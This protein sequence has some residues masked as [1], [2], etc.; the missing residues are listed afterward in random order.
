MNRTHT[1]NYLQNKNLSTYKILD[2]L[3]VRVEETDN[4]YGLPL[5]V[6]FG[7]AARKN[8]KRGF[9]FVSKILGKH[10]PVQPAVSLLGGALLGARIIEDV[11]GGTVTGREEAVTALMERKDGEEELEGLLAS[12]F[13]LPE[14]TL[15]IGFAETAT[16]LGQAVFDMFRN[17]SYIHTTR[18]NIPELA[19]AILFEEEHSHAV[20]QACYGDPE[21]F[22]QEGPIV[23]VDDEITTGKT[24]INIIEAIHSQY[25][26]REYIVASLLDWRSEEDKNRYSELEA[27]LGIKVSTVTLLGGAIEVSGCPVEQEGEY[28]YPHPSHLAEPKISWMGQEHFQ[29]Y[30]RM[31]DLPYL[32]ADSSGN[33][34]RIPYSAMTGRFRGIKDSDRPDIDYFAGRTGQLLKG[35][36]SGGRALCLGTGEFMYLPM[37]IAANM[38]DDVYF[39]STTRSPIHRVDREDYAV[40]S[41]FAF[42]CPDDPQVINHFYNIEYGQYRDI[43]L[44]ME[45][46]ASEERMEPLLQALKQTGTEHII[47]V[48]LNEE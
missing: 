14:H 32:S 15:F 28:L 6:L 41:G 16:S 7:M 9:L 5:D 26:H 21:L 2:A 20:S 39:Q 31:S 43:Y 10:I 23:L 29:A 47:V 33:V 45:R 42:P 44:F 24:A 27:R 34:C 19:S 25:P 8:K 18:E 4:P 36:R 12:P 22:K 13:T 37:K 46:G 1:L 38:G 40:R 17:A 48:T 35:T 3:E 30:K 11:F